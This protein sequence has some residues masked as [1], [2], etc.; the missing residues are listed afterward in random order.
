MD[1]FLVDGPK[2]TFECSSIDDLKLHLGTLRETKVTDTKAEHITATF[3]FRPTAVFHV[4]ESENDAAETSNQ[5]KATDPAPSDGP[6]ANGASL[7]TR[8]IRAHETLMN[9]PADDPVLQK[10]VA[11]HLIAN[12]GAVDGSAWAVRSLSRTSSGWTFQYLC[13]SST[14][15]WLRQNAKKDAKALVGESSGKDGQ[16]P[17][18]LGMH[19]LVLGWLFLGMLT[20][21]RKLVLRS[22]AVALSPLRLRKAIERSQSNSSTRHSTRRWQNWPNCSSRHH[23]RPGRR[24]A[25]GMGRARRERPS[26]KQKEKRAAKRVVQ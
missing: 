9:Q 6:A 22:T 19:T 26:Q 21:M 16:D 1:D 17:V 4:P 11:K 3:E 8:A 13:K 20:V 12:L 24:R 7:P 18:N 14:Q 25:D 5:Q 10:V 2:S 23:H 15:A